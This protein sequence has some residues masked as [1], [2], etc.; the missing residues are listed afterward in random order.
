MTQIPGEVSRLEN[1]D[2]NNSTNI[3]EKSKLFVLNS[4]NP[5]QVIIY[6]SVLLIFSSKTF[7]YKIFR[8]KFFILKFFRLNFFILKYFCLTAVSLLLLR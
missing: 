6:D 7:S 4:R 5:Y 3:Q 2:F 1:S 8:L